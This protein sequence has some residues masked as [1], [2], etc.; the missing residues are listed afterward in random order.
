MT[1]QL[2]ATATEDLGAIHWIYW[3][4]LIIGLIA[5]PIKKGL[6]SATILKTVPDQNFNWNDL[7]MDK[8]MFYS[9]LLNVLFGVLF[10][11]F[12]TYESEGRFDFMRAGLIVTA[13]I[14]GHTY[15]FGY[16]KAK[17][18]AADNNEAAKQ[19]EEAVVKAKQEQLDRDNE[20]K[21]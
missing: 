15:V 14:S 6:E 1:L 17:S 21:L 4:C 13:L 10:F 2:I 16:L 19:A 3:L 8:P 20:S 11:V 9:F 12:I 18:T 5:Y 7:L